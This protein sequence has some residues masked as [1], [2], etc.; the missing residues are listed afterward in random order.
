MG[1]KEHF[2]LEWQI[3]SQGINEAD[4]AR[5]V[6]ADITVTSHGSVV[7]SAEVTERNVDKATMISTFN[8]KISPAALE[9][10]LFFVNEP[11]ATDEAR[12]QAGQYFA[13]GSEVNFVDIRTWTSMSLVTMGKRGRAAFNQALIDQL[14]R[15]DV[16]RS[17]K[18]A[19]NQIIA[20]LT[21]V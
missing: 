9:D 3:E 13:Q 8:S 15:D 1:I 19:W 16:P 10:Y 4:V 20:Q 5:G 6:G 18:L 7:L 17:V 12:V 11:G 2:D 14:S 21:S